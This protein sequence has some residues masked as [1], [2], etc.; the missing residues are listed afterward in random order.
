MLPPTRRDRSV[1]PEVHHD[2]VLIKDVW[3]AEFFRWQVRHY[4]PRRRGFFTYSEEAGIFE[5]AAA[6]KDKTSA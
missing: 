6:V 1:L 4:L 2:Q 5:A 3:P